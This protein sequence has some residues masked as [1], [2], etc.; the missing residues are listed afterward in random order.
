VLLCQPL[1]ELDVTELKGRAKLPEH[2]AFVGFG[3]KRHQTPGEKSA[4]REPQTGD[5]VR[6]PGRVNAT[7][8]DTRHAAHHQAH[9]QPIGCYRGELGAKLVATDS[10]EPI[11]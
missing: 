4:G 5:G 1:L 7:Q 6:G 9:H 11:R 10:I 3:Q 8:N 2:S